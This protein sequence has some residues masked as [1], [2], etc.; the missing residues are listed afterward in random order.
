MSSKSGDRFNYTLNP[1]HVANQTHGPNV[2]PHDLITVQIDPNKVHQKIVGFGASFTGSVTYLLNKMSQNLRNCIYKS[3]YTT[4]I[5]SAFTLMRMPMGGCDFDLE[6]WTY[7]EYPIND[8]KLTNFT[9]LHP[10][11]QQR[12]RLLKDLMHA[13][14][15]SNINITVAAWS[16]P[17][18]MKQE[19][20]WAGQHGNQLQPDYYQT[21][22]DFHV[23]F[24]DLMQ[25]AGITISTISTGNEPHFANHLPFI[26]MNWNASHQ[27][28]WITRY[29]QPALQ[30]SNH[31]HIQL[32]T[33]DD[34][35][36]VLI[37]WLRNLTTAQPNLM[38]FVTTI[39][40]HGYFDVVS[41]STVLD[42]IVQMYPNKSIL[43]TEMCFGTTG[44]VSNTGAPLGVW[45]HADELINMLM[46]NFAHQMSGYID[47]NMVLDHTGGPNYYGNKLDAAIIVN[48]K[49]TEIYKQPTFYAMAQF[50]RFITP[51]SQRIANE[52]YGDVNGGLKCLSFL[53]MDGKIAVVLYNNSTVEAISVCVENRDKRN[54][55]IHLQPKTIGT[56]LFNA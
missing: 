53:R 9:Q 39:G 24:L 2:I 41:S 23:K 43:Y 6:P 31:A 4:S 56:M 28:T 47:W 37:D 3:Y 25:A 42:R 15:N 34:N 29:L 44:P 49:F 32:I 40:V 11:D 27:A 16:A 1:F 17:R 14:E 30:Q 52:V 48:D 51:G 50:S 12:V 18:W 19:Y 33:G 8:T 35:R 10:Y 7:N 38:E 5:G 13:S 54:A 20:R 45:D 46:E 21:W 55:Y 22:A 36:N 26:S